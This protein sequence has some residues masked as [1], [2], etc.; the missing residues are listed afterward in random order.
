MQKERITYLRFYPINDNFGCFV[1][2]NH[3]NDSRFVSLVEFDFIDRVF[4]KIRTV[5]STSCWNE[6]IFV[7]E[8][9]SSKFIL[10]WRNNNTLN[11]QNLQLLN[12]AVK[13]ENTAQYEGCTFWIDHYFDGSVYGCFINANT[14]DAVS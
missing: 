14:W 10:T 7:D 4:R 1:E 9:D 5:E 8:F 3:R 11:I 2:Y 12:G 13:P 6:R